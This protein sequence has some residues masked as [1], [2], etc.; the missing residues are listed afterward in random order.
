VGNIPALAAAAK[1]PDANERTGEGAALRCRLA[2]GLPLP[3]KPLVILLLLLAFGLL[4]RGVL[5]AG[6]LAFGLLARG[7]PGFRLLGAGRCGLPM[8]LGRESAAAAAALS[9]EAAT[10]ALR[11]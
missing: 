3:V 4:A 8:R 11:A 6:K 9:S 5:N 10:S 7:L 1:P 2:F